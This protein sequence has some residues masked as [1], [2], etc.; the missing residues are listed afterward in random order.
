MATHLLQSRN[1]GYLTPGDKGKP[2]YIVHRH[3]QLEML[4]VCL[5]TYLVVSNVTP[6]FLTDIHFVVYYKSHL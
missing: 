5:V 4:N 1:S 2:Y 6:G 3:M